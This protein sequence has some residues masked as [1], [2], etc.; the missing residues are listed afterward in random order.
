MTQCPC[1][2]QQ[3]ASCRFRGSS[4][5]C[6]AGFERALL[7]WAGIWALRQPPA[8]HPCAL[9]AV[10]LVPNESGSHAGKAE[11]AACRRR[12]IHQWQEPA[13]VLSERRP[14]LPVGFPAQPHVRCLGKTA[15]FGE[16]LW[17]E[18]EAACLDNSPAAGGPTR[19]CASCCLLNPGSRDQNRAIHR[20]RVARKME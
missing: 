15:W 7:G 12:G 19:T 16:A 1:R 20:A 9:A 18:R 8:S 3:A 11:R 2:R 17:A 4:Y 5:K 14:V 13:A 6:W 10:C